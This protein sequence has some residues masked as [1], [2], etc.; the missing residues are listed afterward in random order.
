MFKVPIFVKTELHDN[1]KVL[2]TLPVIKGM[3]GIARSVG[4]M[5]QLLQVNNCQC[6]KENNTTS[7]QTIPWH[8][9]HTSMSCHTIPRCATFVF[10]AKFAGLQRWDQRR[11]PH[12]HFSWRS[13][14]ICW[15][16]PRHWRPACLGDRHCWG[17]SIFIFGP[18]ILL[19]FLSRP[20]VEKPEL[21]T[22][23]P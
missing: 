3:V 15:R 19:S 1:L 4:N 13:K 23:R 16:D 11:S 6:I 18:K 5:F 17:E 2:H 7:C 21:W 20:A 8:S 9:K 12:E 22:V 14:S 10:I